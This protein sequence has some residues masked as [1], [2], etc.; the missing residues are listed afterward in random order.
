MELKGGK[1]EREREGEREGKKTSI[2]THIHKSSLSGVRFRKNTIRKL[3]EKEREREGRR[4]KMP[5]Q[6]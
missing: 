3:M 4:E 6:K 5:E 1:R 2:N